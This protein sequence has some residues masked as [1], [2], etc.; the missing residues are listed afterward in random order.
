MVK[1]DNK[2]KTTQKN[3]EQTKAETKPIKNTKGKHF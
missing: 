2:P 3:K 1:K